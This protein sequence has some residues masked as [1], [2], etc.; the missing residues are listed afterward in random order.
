MST[1]WSFIKRAIFLGLKSVVIY[2]KKNVKEFNKSQALKISL[3]IGIYEVF[4]FLCVSVSIGKLPS[5]KIPGPPSDG[6][7]PSS[8]QS[9]PV[10]GLPSHWKETSSLWVR[11]ND[12]KDGYTYCQQV[13]SF[14]PLPWVVTLSLKEKKNGVQ[15]RFLLVLGF[16]FVLCLAVCFLPFN[17]LSLLFDIIF[18]SCPFKPCSCGSTLPFPR[19]E[20]S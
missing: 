14:R 17:G 12:R 6:F 2:R 9:R 7:H 15:Q 13:L 11:L 3:G 18:P 19:G 4:M 20:C 8:K 16:C 5:R 10:G 1:A